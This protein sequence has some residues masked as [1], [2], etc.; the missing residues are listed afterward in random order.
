M[1]AMDDHCLPVAVGLRRRPSAVRK[2][3]KRI[4]PR[5]NR[6]LHGSTVPFA[7]VTR[8]AATLVDF[9]SIPH[10]WSFRIVERLCGKKQ[11]G[12]KKYDHPSANSV[13]SYAY[14]HCKPLCLFPVLALIPSLPIFGSVGLT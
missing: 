6:T 2:V 7:P 3:R 5:K 1:A 12:T 13:A 8:D 11:R 9:L 14:I 10:I 4:C